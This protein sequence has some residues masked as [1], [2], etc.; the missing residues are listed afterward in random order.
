MGGG[1]A[2]A[3]AL[4]WQE[5]SDTS[6]LSHCSGLLLIAPLVNAE[7]VPPAPV[8]AFLRHV[9]APLFPLH[10]V[11]SFIEPVSDPELLWIEKKM[12]DVIHVDKDGQR[13][14]IAWGKNM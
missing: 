6:Q 11:P 10:L 12:Q 7:K 3:T 2:L 1:L 5:S 13:G 8:V 14:G 4:R 9:V